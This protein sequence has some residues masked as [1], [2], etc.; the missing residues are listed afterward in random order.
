MDSTAVAVVATV[1]GCLANFVGGFLCGRL[2]VSVSS[3]APSVKQA[4]A[5]ADKAQEA[6]DDAAAV[7]AEQRE[8][9]SDAVSSD[10]AE[11]GLADILN[12][13]SERQQ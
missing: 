7:A 2:S 9:I 3:G 5:V 6:A 11:G 12:E 4:R 8:E 1:V 10:A 13:R